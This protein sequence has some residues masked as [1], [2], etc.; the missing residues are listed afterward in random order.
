MMPTSGTRFSEARRKQESLTSLSTAS[1]VA[2][3]L[4]RNQNKLNLDPCVLCVCVCESERLQHLSADRTSTRRGKLPLTAARHHSTTCGITE[5]KAKSETNTSTCCFFSPT[6][7]HSPPTKWLAQ[8]LNGLLSKIASTF[9]SL[10]LFQSK[11]NW[12]RDL[13]CHRC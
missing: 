2:F 9:L 6:F 11:Q 8:P 4:L 3:V 10:L 7:S 5:F 1:D 12:S 13:A